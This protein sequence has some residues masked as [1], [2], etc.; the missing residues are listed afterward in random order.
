MSEKKIGFIISGAGAQLPQ[1]MALAY[2]LIEEKGI[3][4][5]RLA[6]T[7]SGAL[8]SVF[9]N[10]ILQY[11]AGKGNFSWDIWKREFFKLSNDQVY[12]NTALL[13]PENDKALKQIFDTISEMLTEDSKIESILDGFKLL[14][15]LGKHHDVVKDLISTILNA[16]K[17]G[18][19]F[20]TTPLKE[21]LS[22]YVNND[23]YIGYKTF[24][25]CFL[26]T[27]IS[28]VNNVN[29]KTRRFYSKN[30][31]DAKYDPVDIIAA[32]TAIPVVLPS[33]KVEDISYIDG[34]TAT[35]GI[36]VEDIIQDGLFDEIYI[37]SPQTPG[38]I[39]GYQH[40]MNQA[41]LL[42]NL[43][44]AL[45]VSHA[46]IKPFQLARA[47][48]LVKDKAKAFYY[49]PS[50]AKNYSQIDFTGAIMEEQF[51]QTLSWARDNDPRVINEFLPEI[52]FPADDE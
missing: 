34:G 4:P 51:N 40:V 31:E 17:E 25:Q 43:I 47:M 3:I 50:L 19:V 13:D 49:M 14:W 7:S 15:E 26:P 38:L 44:F 23:E 29:G 48:D 18:Y 45:E 11:N 12:S 21:T 20:D 1:E 41:P 24:D 10:G 5:T 39:T 32:S 36:P 6:G 42:S 46:A 52:G 9:L 35:D 27:Y 33:Q 37:L 28:A 16:W 8:S 2:R 22:E 30:E